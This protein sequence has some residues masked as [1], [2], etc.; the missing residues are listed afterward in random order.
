MISS[1]GSSWA[2][3]TTH[4]LAPLLLFFRL[5]NVALDQIR[6]LQLL[7]DL[8]EQGL[9]AILDLAQLLLEDVDA[10][11]HAADVILARA[12]SRAVA[13]EE[14]GST[15]LAELL[16]RTAHVVQQS[17]LLAFGRQAVQLAVDRAEIAH[18][19]VEL[20]A[21]LCELREKRLLILACYGV[22]GIT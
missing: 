5:E 11:P 15:E 2:R 17:M 18:E 4:L 19:T 12:T 13:P 14:L 22:H 21:G 10:A 1:K 20:L 3:S 7:L 6:V 16:Q 8:F 9:S